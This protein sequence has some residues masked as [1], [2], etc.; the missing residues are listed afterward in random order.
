MYMS[1]NLQIH[2]YKAFLQVIQQKL[3]AK[4]KLTTQFYYMTNTLLNIFY[5]ISSFKHN[6]KEQEKPDQSEEN[7]II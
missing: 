2:Q 6:A 3:I 7:S 1:S 5:D 4:A